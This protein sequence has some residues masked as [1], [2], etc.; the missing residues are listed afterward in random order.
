MENNADTQKSKVAQTAEKFGKLRRALLVV[1]NFAYIIAYSLF[2]VI[3]MSRE[4][5]DT[6]WLP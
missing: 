1:W 3:S 4:N 6:R 2:C 5:A